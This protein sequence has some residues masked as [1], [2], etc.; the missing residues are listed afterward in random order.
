MAC[1]REGISLRLNKALLSTRSRNILIGATIVK[2]PSQNFSQVVRF[3][4]LLRD[5]SSRTFFLNSVRFDLRESVDISFLSTCVN[6]LC[7][8]DGQRVYDK[9]IVEYCHGSKNIIF[10]YT[11]LCLN[12]LATIIFKMAVSKFVSHFEYNYRMFRHRSTAGS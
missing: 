4:L 3:K 9:K 7:S 8:E 6:D 2:L 10:Y 11:I 1:D 5:I 12:K